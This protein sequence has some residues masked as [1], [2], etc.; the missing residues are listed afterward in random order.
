MLFLENKSVNINMENTIVSV[1]KSDIH[2]RLFCVNAA[3]VYNTC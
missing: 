2:Q 3:F 1:N